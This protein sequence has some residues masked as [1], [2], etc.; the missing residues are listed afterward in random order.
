MKKLIITATDVQGLVAQT[1]TTEKGT[2]SNV[3]VNNHEEDTQ[4]PSTFDGWLYGDFHEWIFAYHPLEKLLFVNYAN[5]NFDNIVERLVEDKGDTIS[6]KAEKIAYNVEFSELDDA[7]LTLI[8]KDDDYMFVR[9]D[10]SNKE[11]VKQFRED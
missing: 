10:W 3:Q 7:V 5:G 11:D 1:E 6:T 9:I 8:S 4:N 2:M